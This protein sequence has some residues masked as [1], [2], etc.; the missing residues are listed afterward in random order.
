MGRQ[1]SEIVREGLD[2]FRRDI[3]RARLELWAIVDNP[4][5]PASSKVRALTEILD[6]GLGKAVEHREENLNVRYVITSVTMSKDEWIAKY[7]KPV[8]R[9]GTGS[10]S[11]SVN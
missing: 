11:G 9:V 3:P 10:G 8:D 5:T 2:L 7:I 4:L 6:R 1:T